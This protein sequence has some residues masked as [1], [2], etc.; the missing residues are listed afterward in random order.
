MH[1]LESPLCDFWLHESSIKQIDIDAS[2]IIINFDNGFW[3]KN[4]EQLKECKMIINISPLNYSNVNS[5]FSVKKRGYFNKEISP[6]SFLKRLKKDHFVIDVEYYSE[7]EKSILLVGRILDVEMEIK[8]T[9]IDC[10]S[11]L[12]L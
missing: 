11:F 6:E 12:Y 8:I 7:F 5:F 9:D 4:H 1:F 2:R 3:N 10:I